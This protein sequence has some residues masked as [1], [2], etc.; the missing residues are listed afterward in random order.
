MPEANTEDTHA[1]SISTSEKIK[2]ATSVLGTVL[3]PIAILFATHE[4]SRALKEREI[5]ASY[6]ELG[7]SILRA[8]PTETNLIVRE[9]AVR[10]VNEF[11]PIPLSEEQKELIIEEDVFTSMTEIQEEMKRLLR[12]GDIEEMK[13]LSHRADSAA[14]E[15]Y[16]ESYRERARDRIEVNSGTPSLIM[17]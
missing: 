6:V 14:V 3:V 17:E 15:K 7:V 9:W 4:Y 8:P 11:A 16:R 13:Q 10:V 5:R 1:T 2:L 12:A